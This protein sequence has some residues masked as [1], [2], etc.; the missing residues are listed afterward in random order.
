MSVSG[1]FCVVLCDWW[2]NEMS[3]FV[4]FIVRGLMS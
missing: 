1:E 4:A 2:H 3:I